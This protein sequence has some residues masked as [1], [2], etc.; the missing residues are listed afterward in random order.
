MG[1]IILGAQDTSMK[2]FWAIVYNGDTD[3]VEL[4]KSLDENTHTTIWRGDAKGW[5][6]DTWYW[7]LVR[8]SYGEFKVYSSS[9]GT[10]FNF[11]FAVDQRVLGKGYTGLFAIPT[12]DGYVDFDS[13]MVVTLGRDWTS[14]EIIKDAAVRCGVDGFRTQAAFED[15]FDSAG[16]FSQNWGSG[17]YKGSWSMPSDPTYGFRLRGTGGEFQIR[18]NSAFRNFKVSWY[19]QVDTDGYAGLFWRS[20]EDVENCYY[21]IVDPGLEDV[22]PIVSLYKREDGSDTKLFTIPAVKWLD[23]AYDTQ[24]HFELSAQD[25]WVSVWVEDAL[26]FSYYDETFADE[27]Y[28]GFLGSGGAYFD[29]VRIGA[30]GTVVPQLVLNPTD[31]YES[32]VQE[33]AE[34]EGGFYYFDGDGRLVLKTSSDDTGLVFDGQTDA[35]STK[36][37]LDWVSIVRVDGE[38]AFGTYFDPELY[39][40][41]GWR[42]RYYQMRELGTAKAC[43]EAAQKKIEELERSLYERDFRAPAQVALEVGDKVYYCLLYTSPSPRD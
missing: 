3:K 28:F 7:L 1:G 33:L 26:L 40:E 21:F 22:D 30:F 35:S 12:T 32:V 5:S 17:G 15:N 34:L 31:S 16:V 11:E 41:R 27:G 38:S 14:E 8:W 25:G 20:D 18:S 10:D 13:F 36:S 24:Y 39:E 23:L 2:E 37:D 29:A 9:N 4:V 43:V 6:G 19:M 42:Y